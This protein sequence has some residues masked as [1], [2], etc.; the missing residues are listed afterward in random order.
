VGD[1]KDSKERDEPLTVSVFVEMLQ[2]T[3]LEFESCLDTA[4]VKNC[5]MFYEQTYLSLFLNLCK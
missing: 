2:R 5:A 1:I 3:W 4:S